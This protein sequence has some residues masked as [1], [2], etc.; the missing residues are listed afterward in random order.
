MVVDA[1]S[2]D[3]LGP[4]TPDHLATGVSQIVNI[5]RPQALVFAGGGAKS[6]HLFEKTFN[7]VLRQRTFPPFYEAMRIGTATV[8]HAM[9]AGA[10]ILL[11][12]RLAT[13]K[14]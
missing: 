9:N 2:L 7:L 3:A 10:A 13:L 4:A 5:L 8:K 6:W 12:E 1:T 11:A 14:T